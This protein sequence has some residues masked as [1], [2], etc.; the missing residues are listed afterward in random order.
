MSVSKSGSS[1]LCNFSCFNNNN[2]INETIQFSPESTTLVSLGCFSGSEISNFEKKSNNF[3]LEDFMNYKGDD[4]TELLIFKDAHG[5]KSSKKIIT[6]DKK[7]FDCK[8]IYNI[9]TKNKNFKKLKYIFIRSCYSAHCFA[10]ELEEEFRKNNRNLTVIGSVNAIIRNH[11]SKEMGCYKYKHSNKISSKCRKIFSI[12]KE[13]FNGK[14]V[15]ELIDYE[16]LQVFLEDL[17]TSFDKTVN[18]VFENKEFYNKYLKKINNY[19]EKCEEHKSYEEIDLNFLKL[20]MK[21]LK[22]I[23]FFIQS[24][25]VVDFYD[26]QNPSWD[27]VYECFSQTEWS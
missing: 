7:E 20:I 15:N 27:N 11:K 23:R 8:R 17:K 24:K 22:K 26:T 9:S 14:E 1:F 2:S 19:I 3:S 6:D 13:K 18:N 5:D 16:D 12:F 21:D 10:L 4:T 25:E